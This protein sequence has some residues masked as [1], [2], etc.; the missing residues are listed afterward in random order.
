MAIVR[1]VEQRNCWNTGPNYSRA[2][3]VFKDDW[4]ALTK[5]NYRIPFKRRPIF[6]QVSINGSC[7]ISH[8]WTFLVK[9]ER[10]TYERS[11][12]THNLNFYAAK[13]S[14]L[15]VSFDVIKKLIM[16]I[17]DER[18]MR[19]ANAHIQSDTTNQRI[20]SYTAS[21][22]ASTSRCNTMKSHQK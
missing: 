5:W 2:Q 15:H 10:K 17:A 18:E 6:D 3:Q 19:N 14:L 7:F 4:I 11:K 16:K 13:G 21:K 1:S 8:T 20:H 9:I 12:E 22:D